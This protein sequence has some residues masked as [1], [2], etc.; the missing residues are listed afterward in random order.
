MMI[1]LD[2]HFFW[3]QKHQPISGK[4]GAYLSTGTKP[5]FGFV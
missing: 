4:T 1:V 2:F 3:V 5:Q